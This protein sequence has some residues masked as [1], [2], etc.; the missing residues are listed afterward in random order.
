MRLGISMNNPSTVLTTTSS[1]PAPVLAV[2]HLTK[3]FSV[4]GVSKPKHVH[5]LEDASFE[6]RPGQIIALVGESGSGKSTTARLIARLLPPT[7][8]EIVLHDQ[9]VLKTEPRR[10][11]LSYRGRVQMIFQDPF[12]SL[13]GVKTIGY[14]LERPLL[15]HQRVKNRELQD[16]VH[17]CWLLSATPRPRWPVSVSTFGRAAPA[18]RH[19]PA[20]WP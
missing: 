6:L 5:A 12:G 7:T 2:R 3:Y 4:G 1:V 14:H 9:D 10:V 8:G 18:R 17:G 20:R 16:K 11:S 19:R 13:N 15:L